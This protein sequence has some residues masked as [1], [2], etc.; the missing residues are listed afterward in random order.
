LLAN[1]SHLVAQGWAVDLSRSG[2]F[3]ANDRLAL[4]VAQPMRVEGG[5]F[6]FNLPTAYSYATLAATN[7]QERLSLVP[8]GREIISELAWRGDLWGGYAS[9]SLFYRTD[10][11]HY[12]GLPD[13][14]GVALTW[15]TKF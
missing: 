1:G 13:E 10:P 12:A 5:G 4:R 8:R 7:S 6:I 9:A 3:A 11:G 2:V 15:G 14:E